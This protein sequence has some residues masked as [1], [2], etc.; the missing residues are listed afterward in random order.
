MNYPALL[1]FVC[2]FSSLSLEILWV[3]FYGFAMNSTPSAFGF[4]LMA[5]LFGIALGA[6]WGGRVCKTAENNV[7]WRYS[8]AALLVSGFLSVVLPA[9]FAFVAGQWWRN[10]LVDFIILAVASFVLAFVF[11]VAHHLGVSKASSAQGKRFAWVYTSNVM[12]AALGPLVTG[13]VLLDFLTLQ[14]AFV[15]VCVFQLLA[16][17]FFAAFL[18]EVRLKWVLTGV[19]GSF[20]VFF[21]SSLV[22]SHALIQKVSVTGSAA[23]QVVENRHGI[24]TVF[25]GEVDGDDAVYG[26][27]VYD[28]R[29]NLSLERNSNGLHRL[30]LL[31]AL[32]P[33]P[34]RILMVGLSIGTWLALVKEFPGVESID[35]VEINPGYIQAAQAYPIHARALEDPRVNIVVDDARRWLRLHPEKTYDLIVMNTTWHWRSNASV[36]LSID[37][38]RLIKQHMG[39][40]GVMAFNTTGSVDAFYTAT[41][42]FQS[43]YRYENFVYCADFD[44]RSRKDSSV[45]RDVLLGLNVG[46]VPIFQGGGVDRLMMK[47]FVDIS[48]VASDMERPL[49]VITDDNLITEFKYGQP[50]LRLY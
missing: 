3:R 23:S 18:G 14:Q 21:V 24:I 26:G 48:K 27:N 30:L 4:V 31:G 36:L 2:G 1:S 38:M 45:A 5:Y 12:G 43:A 32:Q 28:G 17:V 50:F 20:V 37:F 41:T 15:F 7:L 8:V 49:E 19:V 34:K 29:T 6:R 44:F 46:G 13:Y 10:L 33:Q 40:G 16:A 25:P 39:E 9:F 35:V 47:P 22:D 11:P 42:V